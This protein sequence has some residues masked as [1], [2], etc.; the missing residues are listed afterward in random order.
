MNRIDRAGRL[1]FEG[2]ERRIGEHLKMTAA[3]R[4][5]TRRAGVLGIATVLFALTFAARLAIRDP[6]ALLAN[7]YVVPIALLAVEFGTWAG[8]IAAAASL[9]LVLAWSAIETVDVGVLGYSSRIAVL[10][11]TGAVVGWFSE[12]LRADIVGREL[13]QRRLAMYVDEL[14]RSND[15]LGR[16]VE[17]LE[18]FAAI[19][20]A[21]GGETDIQR[22]LTLILERG[23]EILPGRGLIAY[24]REGDEL[25]AVDSQLLPVGWPH[26][27]AVHESLAG[28]VLLTGHPRQVSMEIEAERAGLGIPWDG[29]AILVPLLFRGET[30]GVLCAIDVG[31]EERFPAEDEQLL[32][33]I[34]AS[35][36]T[37]VTNA[38]SVAAVRLRS[39]LEA[40]EEARA[41][42]A[43]ELH[44]ETLQGLSG[45]RMV[46]TAGLAQRQPGALRGAGE[47]AKE[48]LGEEMR[49][50]R[51]LIH[52]LRPA[53]LDDLGLA[54]AIGSLAKRQA[55]LGGFTPELTLK[56]A[57]HDRL[58]RETENVIYRIVQEALSN[59]VKHAAAS[60]VILTVTGFPDRVELTVEDDGPGFETEA[61]H[62]G[63]GLVGMRERA[64]L[65]G[66]QL[67]IASLEDGGTRVSAVLPRPASGAR[68]SGASVPKP[69]LGHSTA[70]VPPSSG[71]A[72]ADGGPAPSTV[73][74]TI[75]LRPPAIDHLN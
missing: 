48:H 73:P 23:R 53:A 42:W 59:V 34:A 1:Q 11:V 69:I 71:V 27:L 72:S 30:L 52:E 26:R 66:G 29:V 18:A 32:M 33:S 20:R 12:R 64:L 3:P 74:P 36:A 7:F 21:V 44:D 4:S 63:F 19:A 47:A 57:S 40:A 46:L 65:V 60:R 39:S 61:A 67:R 28:E 5:T 8:V 58:S 9:G 31:D 50:L 2:A 68:S 41:R 10:F 62:E 16:S 75:P 45:V 56:L 24:L 43:R 49:K 51:H 13:A 6:N 14:E 22:V 17:R 25:V 38:R 70:G 15:Q 37:A 54:P 55:T 35:A